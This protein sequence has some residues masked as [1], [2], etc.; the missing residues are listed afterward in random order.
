M[1]PKISRKLLPP[2]LLACPRP[3]LSARSEKSSPRNRREHLARLRPPHQEIRRRN[4]PSC[5]Q[6]RR[7][8]KPPPSPDRCCPSKTQPD[9]KLSASS[10]RS[11]LR[12]PRRAT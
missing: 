5:R 2:V 9:R 1:P 8:H 3:P 6:R 7:A 12:W 10:H 4:L 11:E